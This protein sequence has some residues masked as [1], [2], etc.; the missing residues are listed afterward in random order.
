MNFSRV[1]WQVVIRDGLYEKIPK[2]P[3]DNWV[4]SPQ[5]V[6]D[7]HRP[8]RWGYVQFSTHPPGAASYRADPSGPARDYLMR[9][10]HAQAAHR[11][12]T[13]TWADTAEALGLNP[14]SIP[15]GTRD[16]TI[17]RKGNGYEAALTLDPHDDHPA[18]TWTVREDSRLVR[19]P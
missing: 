7:M 5:G 17:R 10:Y 3:E 14:D 16:L 6:I 18:E 4:W 8:E 13:K 12:R 11:A 1:E 9:V 19:V 15:P 2:M